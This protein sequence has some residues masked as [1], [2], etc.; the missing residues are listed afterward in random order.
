MGD[1][2]GRAGAGYWLGA[3]DEEVSWAN[4][5]DDLD[6]AGVNT[7]QRGGGAAGAGYCVRGWQSVLV[8]HARSRAVVDQLPEW[9]RIVAV[10]GVLAAPEPAVDTLVTAGQTSVL[11]DTETTRLLLGRVPAA[12]HAGVQDILLIAFGLAWTEFL[13]GGGGPIS[14]DVE[15]HG[16]DEEAVRD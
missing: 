14:I 11:L 16:R 6:A 10:P 8:E 1:L 9:R 15:G 12:F 4:L 13:G 7:V 3:V 2:H 5:V